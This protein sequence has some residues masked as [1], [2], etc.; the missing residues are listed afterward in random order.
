MS[1]S[2]FNVGTRGNGR[3]DEEE[4]PRGKDGRFASGGSS[5]EFK[6]G[7]LAG[8]T[9]DEAKI[10]MNNLLEIGRKMEEARK[11]GNN[12]ELKKLDAEYSKLLRRFQES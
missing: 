1:K 3:W 8:R 6:K 12:D 5:G 4:H 10:E 7:D 9:D 11:A 2:R